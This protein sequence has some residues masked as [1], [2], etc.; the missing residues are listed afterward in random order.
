MRATDNIAAAFCCAVKS[1]FVNCRPFI[2]TPQSQK[3]KK[4]PRGLIQFEMGLIFPGRYTSC[5]TS[6]PQ[7]WN[8]SDAS[9]LYLA[10][11]VERKEEA[12][13]SWII[14]PIFLDSIYGSFLKDLSL[15][16][17]VLLLS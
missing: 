15:F 3:K 1:K 13:F 2:W 7:F 8:K 6:L 9:L 11:S 16:S 4:S 5:C 14:P 12:L 17:G 10:F